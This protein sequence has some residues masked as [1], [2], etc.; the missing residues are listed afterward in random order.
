MFCR[1]SSLNL[2]ST[3]LPLLEQAPPTMVIGMDA[4]A[5]HPKWNNGMV[6]QMYLRYTCVRVNKTS[7]LTVTGLSKDWSTRTGAGTT[8]GSIRHAS[9]QS[10]ALQTEIHTGKLYIHRCHIR[11]RKY[12]VSRLA[13]FWRL[14]VRSPLRFLSGVIVEHYCSCWGVLR[15]W[16]VDWLIKI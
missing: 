13:I 4:S 15:C 3:L 5:K 16:T 7:L 14:S 8:V 1:P 10:A 12:S 11:W 2:S 6:C 9:S